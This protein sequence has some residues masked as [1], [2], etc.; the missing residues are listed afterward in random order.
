MTSYNQLDGR[1]KPFTPNFRYPNSRTDYEGY[2]KDSKVVRPI[3]DTYRSRT[4]WPCFFPSVIGLIVSG[5]KEETNVMPS[6]CVTVM[7]RAPFYVGFPAFSGGGP[8]DILKEKEMP[9]LTL[10]LIKKFR[11]F[12]MNIPY[13]DSDLLQSIRVV[14]SYSGT[15]INKFDHKDVKLTRLDSEMISS[16]ILK[17]CPLNLECKL[18]QTLPLGTHDWVIG[19]VVNVHLDKEF[20]KNG[21][22]RFLWRS[23][24]EVEKF[25]SERNQWVPIRDL[26]SPEV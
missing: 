5:G 25:D 8:D 18:Y 11:D 10:G 4:W 12:S 1:L 6:S 24:P 9:R 13:I 3:D 16:P 2:E 20:M 22:R 21:T 7:D 17:E 26:N 23:I 14:G 15:E 19:E